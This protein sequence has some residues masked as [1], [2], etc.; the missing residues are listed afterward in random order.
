MYVD[1]RLTPSD[2]FHVKF[3]KVAGLSTRKGNIVLLED[4]L[5]EA[6]ERMLENI[7]KSASMSTA[8]VT[9]TSRFC[10]VYVCLKPQST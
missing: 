2:N 7:S 3:G 10:E 8:L 1:C 9:K 4:I 6:R 5:N